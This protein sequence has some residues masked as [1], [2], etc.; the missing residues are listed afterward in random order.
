VYEDTL[1]VARC[2]IDAFEYGYTQRFIPMIL[3]WDKPP[4]INPACDATWYSLYLCNK[5]LH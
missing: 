5:V 2:D 4:T 3:R 1:P